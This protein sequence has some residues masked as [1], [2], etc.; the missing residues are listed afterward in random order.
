MFCIICETETD[1]SE[2]HIIPEALGNKKF[3]TNRV[4]K[5][6][7]NKLGTNVDSYIIEHPLIKIIRKDLNIV[8][9]SG[10]QVKLFPSHLC[11]TSGRK[12]LFKDDVP[13]I[14]PLVEYYE[15]SILHIEANNK[16]KAIELARAN[17]KKLGKPTEEIDHII[18]NIKYSPPKCEQPTF[19]LTADI[20]INRFYIS[21]LK[22]AYEFAHFIIGDEYL[23]DEIALL[24]KKIIINM[25]N[26]DKNNILEVANS[27]NISHVSLLQN[28][29]EEILNKYI[30][31]LNKM[32]LDSP[33]RHMLLLHGGAKNQLIC[34]I[35]LF[36]QVATSF[37]VLLSNQC[38]DYFKSTPVKFVAILENGDY[39]I[40]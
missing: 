14:A 7:N 23:N 10:K 9:K 17:L 36:L 27:F 34:E 1:L 20:H 22:I 18:S 38:S 19:V 26:A 12:Y 28:K 4:C 31:I 29:G 35:Y 39:F 21:A 13:Y 16:D 3:C 15:N 37:T 6:C 40:I 2:E 25:M 24:T 8:G 11:S 5:N 32:E 33:I 30:P